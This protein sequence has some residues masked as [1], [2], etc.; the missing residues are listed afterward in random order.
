MK[1]QGSRSQP[2]PVDPGFTLIELLVVIAIIAILAGMLLSA[3][4][5]ARHKAQA[6][7]CLSNYRQLQLAWGMYTDDHQG[8]LPRN[9]T[10]APQATECYD[11][12]PG[13]MAVA[14][15]GFW[16]C[17]AFGKTYASTPGSWVLGNARRDL[18]DSGI[19]GGSLWPYANSGEKV[20]RCPADRSTVLGQPRLSRRRSVSLSS[21]MNPDTGADN[22]YYS[23]AWHKFHDITDPPPTDALVF[24][25]EH[26]DS[27]N[28]GY[29]MIGHTNHPGGHVPW[30][31]YDAPALRHRRACTVTFADGHAKVWRMV[32]PTTGNVAVAGRS[33]NDR[34]L[35]RF[36]AAIP[37][38]VPIRR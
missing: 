25:D 13:A 1:E 29:F 32:E 17:D 35:S 9:G 10:Q 26:Q 37:W 11:P 6:I 14:N 23:R 33:D 22:A 36:Y 27:I 19:K 34:D 18:D 21:Y 4:G 28:D 7:C 8:H 15:L 31:W 16:R 20:Y 3:L 2:H 12:A 30:A 5:Q 24:V 38:T